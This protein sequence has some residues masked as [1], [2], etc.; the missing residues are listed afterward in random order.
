MKKLASILIAVLLTAMGLLAAVAPAAA[1]SLLDAVEVGTPSSESTHGIVEQPTGDWGPIETATHGGSYGDIDNGGYPDYTSGDNACRCIWG[2]DEDP[3]GNTGQDATFT[4]STGSGMTATR[5]VIRVLD[6][7][8]D[9]SFDLEV[10]GSTELSYTDQYTTETWVTH[11]I[12]ISSGA[13][14]GTLNIR[15]TATAAAG[16]Y[17]DDFGQV[18]VDWAELY[19]EESPTPTPEGNDTRCFIATVAYG[20]PS[21]AD[22]DTLRGFRDAFLQNDAAGSVFV[23]AYYALSPPI[24]DFI[25]AHPSLKPVAKA[26]LAPAVVLSDSAVDGSIALKAVIGGVALLAAF[27]STV[28]FRRRIALRR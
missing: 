24:A 10:N 27:A 28:W 9:D 17:F 13:Y 16:P 15:L 12:D 18:A 20:S 2:Y 25:D 23:S 11:D 22:V 3:T 8:S 6:G 4:M 14:T 21:A 1:D 5:L 7:G 19:G 26:A